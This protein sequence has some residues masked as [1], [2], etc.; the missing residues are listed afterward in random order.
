MSLLTI[1][2]ALKRHICNSEL[3]SQFEGWWPSVIGLEEKEVEGR[4]NKWV[5]QVILAAASWVV[6][7]KE[8]IFDVESD[9]VALVSW[10]KETEFI[11]EPASI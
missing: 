6:A 10:N 11:A 2:H 1:L 8:S 3:A 7:G 4:S 9:P 5:L